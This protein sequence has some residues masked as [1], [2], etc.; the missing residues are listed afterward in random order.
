MLRVSET[1]LNAF[2]NDPHLGGDGCY[3]VF[4]LLCPHFTLLVESYTYDV[5]TIL[6]ISWSILTGTWSILTSLLVESY[7][8][9]IE[10]YLHDVLRFSVFDSTAELVG[11]KFGMVSLKIRRHP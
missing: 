7:L 6:P 1:F 3:P 10:S 5:D 4:E 8:H 9:G 2:A 11:G